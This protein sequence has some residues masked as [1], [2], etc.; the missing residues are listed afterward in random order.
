M[1]FE[2]EEMIAIIEGKQKAYSDILEGLKKE[3]E[4]PEQVFYHRMKAKQQ[5]CDELLK[6]Y[7]ARK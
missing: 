3:S 7:E 1:A 6:E 2:L 5:L 4:I